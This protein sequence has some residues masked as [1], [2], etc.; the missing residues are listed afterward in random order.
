[1]FCS[2]F[3]GVNRKQIVGYLTELEALRYCQVGHYLKFPAFPVWVVGRPN[4]FTS[5]LSTDF[6]ACKLGSSEELVQV[7]G[8]GNLTITPLLLS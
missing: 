4:H 8:Q 7:N 5:M 1:M 6:S 3:S 2:Q